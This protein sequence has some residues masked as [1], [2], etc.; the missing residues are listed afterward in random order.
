MYL[1]TSP[2]KWVII[3]ISV[4]WLLVRELYTYWLAATVGDAFTL[5]CLVHHPQSGVHTRVVAHLYLTLDGGV[6]MVL[7]SIVRPTV[8]LGAKVIVVEIYRYLPTF[9]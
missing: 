7:H 4:F 6:P 9:V 3:C 8:E 5:L 2:V 1:L